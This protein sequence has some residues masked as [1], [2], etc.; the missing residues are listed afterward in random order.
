MALTEKPA[1]AEV[2]LVRV[3]GP[4][5]RY[6][7]PPFE[8]GNEAALTHGATS[9]RHIRPLTAN[10]RRRVLRKMRL[11]AGDIDAVGRAYLERVRTVSPSVSP[12][13]PK[14]PR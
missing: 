1:V 6:S 8:P 14:T 3:G 4:A 12:R 7:W 2:A 13:R 10:H 11:R 9:E 5:R